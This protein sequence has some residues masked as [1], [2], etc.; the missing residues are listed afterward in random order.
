MTWALR[1]NVGRDA[2]NL[3]SD[4]KVVQLLL[5]R[6]QPHYLSLL[7]VDGCAVHRTTCAIEEFQRE[8]LQSAAPDGVVA[9]GSE[10][11]CALRGRSAP[12]SVTL[13]WGA[14]VDEAF[15]HKVIALCLKLDLSPDFLMAAMAL[16]TGATFDPAVPNAAGS[17]AVGLIQF[18][19]A[20]AK[21]LGTSTAALKAMTALA[22]LDYV[23]KYF[24]PKAGTL[25]SIEDVYMAILYPAAIGR[26]PGDTL[27]D[28]GTKAYTQNKGFDADKDGR[29]SIGEV[30]ATIRKRYN[31]GVLP[32]HLG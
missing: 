20:T 24:K 22:Q 31:A 26:A 18:M 28:A 1:A 19:P 17:G 14:K 23:E 32:R 27:F 4:V 10:T 11:L 3:P 12:S 30:S 21:A 25:H 6:F 8:V 5:N 2:I 15:K 29:I 9:P 7:R 13:A 16:E